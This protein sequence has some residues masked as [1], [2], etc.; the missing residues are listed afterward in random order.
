MRPEDYTRR[1]EQVEGWD[2]NIVSYKLGKTYRCTID[3]VSP[4]ANIARGEGD[5]REAA[6]AQALETARLR[7]ARTRRHPV[8]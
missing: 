2:I 6:E 7:L 1:R 8:S 4:G 3:N 5:S